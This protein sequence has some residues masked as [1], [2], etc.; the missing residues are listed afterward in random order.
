[1]ATF[2]EKNLITGTKVMKMM[3]V[4]VLFNSR[5]SLKKTSNVTAMKNANAYVVTNW[6][7]L[8]P[9]L[10]C[11]FGALKNVFRKS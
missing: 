2:S 9:R 4:R 10:M 3:S 7:M 8:S 1:M 6:F 5:N 11:D